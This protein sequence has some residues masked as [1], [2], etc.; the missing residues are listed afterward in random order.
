MA[1]NPQGRDATMNRSLPPC[2]TCGFY[3]RYGT[4]DPEHEFSPWGCINTLRGRLEERSTR[5]ERDL[6]DRNVALADALGDLIDALHD[7]VAYEIN[8]SSHAVEH[9][10]AACALLGPQYV[11]YIESWL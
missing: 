10:K 2:T 1:I 9:I 11:S 4:T 5:D 8:Q 3:H 7:E 6:V